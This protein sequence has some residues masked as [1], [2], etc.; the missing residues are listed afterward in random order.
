MQRDFN[1]RPWEHEEPQLNVPTNEDA[2][3]EADAQRLDSMAQQ[4]PAAPAQTGL[5]AEEAGLL[6]MKPMA[7]ASPLQPNLGTMGG[8]HQAQASA[9]DDFKPELR[10]DLGTQDAPDLFRGGMTE[11]RLIRA[12]ALLRKYKGGKT[13]LEQRIVKAQQWWKLR[14]WEQMTH[15][16]GLIGSGYKSNTAWLWNCIIGKHADAMDAFPEPVILPRAADDKDEAKRLNEI[17]P[18]VMQENGFEETFS[19]CAWQKLQE[20]TGIYAVSW[21]KDKLG[22]MGDISI[23]RVSALNLF[24]EPGINDIQQSRNVFYCTLEDND[25]LEQMY[26]ELRGKVKNSQMT[27]ARYMY[28]DQVDV[29]DKSVVIDW[30]Y[31]T[32]D[33]A[34]KTL[35]YCKFVGHTVLYATEDDPQYAERGLYDDGDYP[36]V[37]DALYPMEGSPC[38]IGMI[39]YAKGAQQDIDLINQAMV[40]SVAMASTPRFFVRKDGGVNENE[41]ADWSKPIVHTSGS[42]G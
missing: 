41:F 14:N 28:D 18:V 30:Y 7:Q 4:T 27:L 31:H 42:L 35:H 10:G 23:N 36:F 26:P 39:D 38:G 5:S 19:D 34:R 40:R 13:N 21:D 12:E 6:G 24:W 33:G 2:A 11:E 20:G 3:L 1:R 15:E 37:F 29:T 22:G 25:L 8:M 32:Y 17:V 9:G 16:E